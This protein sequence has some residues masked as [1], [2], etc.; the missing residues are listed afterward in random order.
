MV[1]AYRRPPHHACSTSIQYL[2]YKRLMISRAATV[3]D[4]RGEVADAAVRDSIRLYLE[5]YVAYVQTRKLGRG[6]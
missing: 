1:P 4:A 5:G 3:F 6:V 2:D